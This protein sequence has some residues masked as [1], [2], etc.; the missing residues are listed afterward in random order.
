MTTAVLGL[1][2]LVLLGLG[3]I[4][5]GGFLE[6]RVVQPDDSRPVPAI[7]Q[8]DGVDY[9]PAP[10]PMLFGHHFAT[11]AGAGP[12]IGPVLGVFL[13][14]WGPV[15][16]WILL[17]SIFLGAVHDYLSLM[18]SARQRGLSVAEITRD[19]V[20]PRA[21]AA[22][23]VFLWAA[24]VLVIAVFG[25]TAAKALM[26]L[27][28]EARAA[29]AFDIGP[30]MV[31]PTFMV[32]VI[33]MMLGVAR[34]VLR[35]PL[36]LATIVALGA[37]FTC[38]YIGYAYLPISLSSIVPD[39]AAQTRIWFV[40]LM[41]YCLVASV[42]PV[43]L[44]LQPRDYISMWKLFACLSTGYIALFAADAAFEAPAFRGF[45]GLNG[46]PMW[47]MLFVIVACG[48]ISGFHSVAATGTSVKQLPRESLGRVV[49]YG[50]MIA[51]A[52]L[53]VVAVAAV[54]AGL[55]WRAGSGG[56]YA[57]DIIGSKAAG[58]PLVAFAKG[59]GR[60]V[61]LGLPFIGVNFAS[62]LGLNMLKTFVITTLDSATRLARFIVAETVGRKWPILANRWVG[63]VATVLPAFLLGW[64]GAWQ[65]IWPVFGAANQLVAAL[66]L[67]TVSCWLLATRK[68]SLV[69]ILPGLFML[70]TTVA[71]FAWQ[72]YGF[73][74]HFDEAGVW[75]PN[76]VLGGTALLLTVLALFVA[77]EAAGRARQLLRATR[78]LGEPLPDLQE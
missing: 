11:I 73:V 13:F 77:V 15:L 42:L 8:R 21:A 61:Q 28:P 26:P 36:W 3:Y 50:S 2:A 22:F 46:S 49:G 57:P 69:A 18:M 31:F 47:P 44:L 24:L 63:T 34:Y 76:W 1:V 40:L 39:Y 58:G 45:T 72:A 65:T 62:V 74:W 25:V 4:L 7:A 30:R 71:A 70:I 32:V 17:G 23:A 75:K 41:G 5:Y 53:A 78:G 48:A 55:S 19:V 14:G 68:P 51:E 35:V 10:G 38:I 66:A 37:V 12:I 54:S 6:R 59:Y 43:W 29:G 20:S 52:L 67:L 27:S 33:A 56:I 60:L 9:E 64:S 16:V